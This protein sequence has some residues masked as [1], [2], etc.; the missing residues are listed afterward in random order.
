MLRLPIVIDAF[1]PMYKKKTFSR[2]SN[3][4]ASEECEDAVNKLST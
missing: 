2:F 4:L 1:K 3:A